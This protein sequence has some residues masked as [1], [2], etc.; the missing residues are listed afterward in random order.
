MKKLYGVTTAMITPFDKNGEVNLEKVEMLVDFLIQ[1]GSNCLYPLGTTG[2]ML[3]MNIQERK[4]VATT[5]VKKANNRV[6]VFIHTG[7]N[8]IN[9]VISLSKHAHSIGADGVGIVTPTFFG[10]N[11]RELISYYKAISDSLP[12]DFSIY[13]YNIPQCA[14]NDIPVQTV[15]EIV[16][17]CKN[18]VG[19]KYSGSDMLRTNDYL[20]INDSQFSVVQGTDRLFL[21][22]LSMGCSG[23][24]SG[25]SCIYPEPFAEIYKAWLE[26]NVLAAQKAQ[27]KANVFC[28]A[29][30]CGANLAYFKH[31]LEHRGVFSSSIRM[32]QLDLNE[33]E[34]SELSST[35]K[36]YEKIYG[37]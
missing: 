31:A 3:K 9:E 7:A 30:L 25:I 11:H 2:E 1:K 26:G 10:I 8:D 5:V 14:A 23:T 12:S 21:P 17:A 29:L 24:V 34:A 6:P 36:E 22:A 18:V 13:L 27:R 33:K 32:P 4:A 20:L 16:K 35:L 19:I 28:E 37:I 15:K